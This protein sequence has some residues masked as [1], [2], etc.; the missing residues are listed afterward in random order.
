MA[1]GTPTNHGVNNPA[2]SGAT[3]TKQPT[4]T[5]A[6]G[7]HIIVA[8]G[9]STGGLTATA[10]DT[11]GNT[12]QTDVTAA[13]GGA[14]VVYI[15]SAKVTTQLTTAD[16]VTVTYSASASGRIMS[17]FSVTGLASSSWFDQGTS[18]NGSSASPNSGNVTT[19]QADELLIGMVRNNAGGGA[20]TWGGGF[21]GLNT[22]QDGGASQWQASGY[23]IVSA[24]DT[25]A[26]S[27]TIISAGWN[28][29]IAT[30]KGAAGGTT[31]TAAAD[32]AG[33]GAVAATATRSAVVSASVAG[34]GAV[35]STATRTAVI[36]A[37]V[38]GAGAFNGTAGVTRIAAGSVSGTGAISA[39]ATVVLLAAGDVAGAG[40]I[41]ATA[42]L[43]ALAA[44]DVSGTGT[45]SA[46]AVGG[47]R[48]FT[49]NGTP[50]FNY[51]HDDDWTYTPVTG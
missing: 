33:A 42:T 1:I 30:Y 16:T 5:I 40:A 26:A 34:A 27:G 41:A 29:A 50:T 36:A 28:A 9:T 7:E 46:T 51:T 32:V 44:A 6:V 39:T 21:T 13:G 49:Y 48:D 4:G 19:T 23:R 31:H 14:R 2:G 10:A 37:Q 45:I 11:Q 3:V 8:V 25:Y 35:A 18:A 22:T 20:I 43:T 12:Y 17:L 47:T 15:I 24:T 38:A